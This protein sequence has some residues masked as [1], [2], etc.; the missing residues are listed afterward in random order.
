MKYA[1][2]AVTDSIGKIRFGS[3]SFEHAGSLGDFIGKVRKAT[4]RK[5]E[6]SMKAPLGAIISPETPRP[7]DLAVKVLT[8]VHNYSL[9]TEVT[10]N[11]FKGYWQ[12]VAPYHAVSVRNSQYVVH[13][14]KPDADEDDEE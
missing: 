14:V 10:I 8:E 2:N 1:A 7:T 11:K 9:H 13:N 6:K 12:I 3:S 4:Q 5:P